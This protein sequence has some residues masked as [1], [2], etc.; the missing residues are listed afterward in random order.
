MKKCKWYDPTCG[1]ELKSA[2]VSG[3]ALALGH[4]SG[5]NEIVH[6]QGGPTGTI[7]AG[8]ALVTGIRGMFHIGTRKR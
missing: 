4:V 1:G 5:V 8:A 7:A 3:L 2:V 6:A